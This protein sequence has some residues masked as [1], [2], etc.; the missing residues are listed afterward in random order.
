MVRTLPGAPPPIVR[1]TSGQQQITLGTQ[2]PA[3][4][5]QKVEHLRVAVRRFEIDNHIKRLVGKCQC[6]SVPLA[7]PKP[8]AN[9]PFLT[10]PDGLG[11]QINTPIRLGFQPRRQVI[12][13]AA[14]T[15][16]YFQNVL[17]APVP[18]GIADAA[19]YLPIKGLATNLRV[20]FTAI[21]GIRSGL[22]QGEAKGS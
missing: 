2:H 6:F 5:F 14:P 7:E 18:P 21:D 19:S 8:L 1:G 11:A 13:S 17:M 12:R 22:W 9:M 20:G 15:A 10:E 16:A 4:L 3:Y